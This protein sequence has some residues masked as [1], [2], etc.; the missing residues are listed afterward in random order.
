MNNIPY[1]FD[2]TMRELFEY[3]DASFPFVTWT[4]DFS[5]FAD[6]S[7]VC[8]WHNEFE[9][10]LLLSGTLDYYID[11]K[12][13]RATSGDVVFINAN[14]MH[15]ATQV[16]NENAVIYT[17]SFL[18]SLL[19]GSFGT[20]FFKKYFQP[21]LQSSVKGFLINSK[22]TSGQAS[23]K[24]LNEIY[25]LEKDNKEHYELLCL[26]LISCIWN[27][28]LQYIKEQKNHL[29]SF[30]TNHDSQQKAKDILLYIHEHYADNIQIDDI[31]QYVGVSR[32]EC[33]RC[34]KRYINRSPIVYLTEYRLSYAVKL[35]TETEKSITEIAMDCGF[36]NASYFGKQFKKAYSVTPLQF[37]KSKI[38][39]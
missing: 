23:I 15:M 39:V 17:V 25:H 4:G 30:Y 8:H 37:R 9:Y 18:P 2:H 38:S 22:T 3:P 29:S 36:S 16:G 5:T 10:D 34:L 14:S 1:S 35:L 6:H 12:N 11:G 31:A 7:L 13:I 33:F 27:H 26:G 21:I 19:N 32:S 24:L 28:T 20:T